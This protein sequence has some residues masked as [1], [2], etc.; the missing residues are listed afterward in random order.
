MIGGGVGCRR[1]AGDFGR[2]WG[3]RG[4][5]GGRLGG[6]VTSLALAARERN[7]DSEGDRIHSRFLLCLTFTSLI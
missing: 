1:S 5:E 3:E 2:R 7:P 6:E 4:V